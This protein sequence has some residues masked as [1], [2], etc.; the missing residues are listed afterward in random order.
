MLKT[1]TREEKKKKT[2]FS[3]KYLLE[4]SSAVPSRLN[5]N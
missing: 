1:G 3:V 4:I 5:K 2:D